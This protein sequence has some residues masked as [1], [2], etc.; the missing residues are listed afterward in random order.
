MGIDKLLNFL[1]NNKLQEIE[2]INTNSNIRKILVN[3]IMINN[4]II[5]YK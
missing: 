2:L 3:H 5:I 1:N 4:S